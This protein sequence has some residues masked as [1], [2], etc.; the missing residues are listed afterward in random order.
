MPNSK[1]LPEC[2]ILKNKKIKGFAKDKNAKSK[3]FTPLMK[4]VKAM[5][6][7]ST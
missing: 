2:R 6:N 5:I 1:F 7:K 3:D 4:F